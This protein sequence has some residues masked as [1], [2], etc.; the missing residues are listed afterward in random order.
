M[1]DNSFI[2]Q[3]NN[4]GSNLSESR[5]SLQL[6][7]DTTMLKKIEAESIDLEEKVNETYLKLRLDSIKKV[8]QQQLQAELDINNKLLELE[9]KGIKDVEKYRDILEKDRLKKEKEEKKQAQRELDQLIIRESPIFSKD[10]LK[11]TLR[12]GAVAF[13]ENL[14]KAMSNALSK[15]WS[16]LNTQLSSSV[17]SVISQYAKYQ[18][19][20]NTRIQG[21]G[22]DFSTLQRTLVKGTGA[23]P[24]LKTED[25]MSNLQSLA[26]SGIA[27]NLEQ[28]AFLSTIKDKIAS[29]FDVANSTLLRIIR[30]QNSDSTAA[31]LG[32]EAALTSYLN[33]LYK[34]SSYMNSSSGITS[35]LFEAIALQKS[36]T[37]SVSFEYQVQKWLGSLSSVGMSESGIQNIASAI[38]QLGSGNVEGLSSSPLQN[39]LVLSA[40]RAGLDYADML[41]KGL[42]ESN[43]NLLL[44]SMVEYL[45]EI[46]ESTNN[47]VVLSQY[48]KILG[49]SVSDIKSAS[50]KLL[51]IT[52]LS[53][54]T[55]SYGQALGS[56]VNQMGQLNSRTSLA[57]K[58]ENVFANAMYD[59][60]TG[61]ADNAGLYATWK[62]TSMIEDLTGGINIPTI[63]ALGN[64]VDLNAT[65][66]QLMKLGIVGAGSL[67][68]IGDIVKGISTWNDPTQMLK[69][70]NILNRATITNSQ[71]GRSTRIVAQT[72][73]EEYSE[74]AIDTATSEAKTTY[75]NESG[76]EDDTQ[77]IIVEALTADG[78]YG[79]E[80]SIANNLKLIVGLLMGWDDTI[81]S[82]P[83]T[84]N[85]GF[86][87]GNS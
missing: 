11:A 22:T 33:S 48:A 9:K 27:F 63:G 5:Q 50:S 2:N 26:T 80:Y 30:L 64:F 68:I 61:I 52:E 58:L 62:V 3:I 51:D 82:L 21:S 49:L 76:S 60:G 46:S 34:D 8:K 36:D 65:V 78:K 70:L 56:L 10:R 57:E 54:S 37:S 41:S 31:R 6:S 16:Q 75:S 20:I 43:T 7:D 81:R 74:R 1:A 55:M 39:L 25:L 24:Y 19:A 66:T 13:G 47:N 73:G 32:M 87:R 29:T 59:L 79:G 42:D 12:E 67:G 28:R 85:I 15:G 17:D 35:A 53:T 38:G 18:S 23:T 71:A 45:K 40:S 44:R 72:V 69:N 86:N 4:Q 83:D 14:S 77:K 84:I